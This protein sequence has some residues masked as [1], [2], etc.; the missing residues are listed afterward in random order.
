MRDYWK[1]LMEI[2]KEDEKYFNNYIQYAKRIKEKAKEILGDRR[3]RVIVFGS[4]VA[5]KSDAR[6]DIDIL[7]ISEKV[8]NSSLKQAEI[9]AELLKDIGIFAPFQIH[10]AT[11][12][13]YEQWYKRFIKE[14]VEV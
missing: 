9:I 10:L 3:L 12:E 7:I 11:P 14:W 1:V 2:R 13:I 4:V 6:S 8:S 5:G